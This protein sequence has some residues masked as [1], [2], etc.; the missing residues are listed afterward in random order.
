[1]HMHKSHINTTYFVG[2]DAFLV[3][4]TFFTQVIFD[5]FRWGGMARPVLAF[6]KL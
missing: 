6:L 5:A 1:M 3:K 2:L 4:M